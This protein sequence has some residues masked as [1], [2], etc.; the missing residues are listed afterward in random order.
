MAIEHN[1]LL[2]DLD[3]D[4]P[5]NEE[6]MAIRYLFVHEYL[7]DHDP[8]SA[9]RRC[10]FVEIV[11][12]EYA[13]AF[14]QEPFVQKLLCQQK[15]TIPENVEED[16]ALKEQQVMSML[17][18]IGSGNVHAT[19]PQVTAL[20]IMSDILHL[21]TKYAPKQGGSLLQ[22]GVMEVPGLIPLEAWESASKQSQEQLKNEVR[23]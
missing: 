18:A 2:S 17:T 10:G 20:N 1:I 6:E 12:K 13:I 3:K 8:V 4:T 23:N 21:K 5:L 22:S 14:M 9:A 11:A 19:S 15:L 7:Q 16:L